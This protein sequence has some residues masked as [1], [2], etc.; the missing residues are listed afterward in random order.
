MS[1]NRFKDHPHERRAVPATRRRAP[2][3]QPGRAVRAIRMIQF[4]YGAFSID[5]RVLLQ[6]YYRLLGVDY[7][8]GKVFP[9]HVE[10]K[11]YDW[12]DETFQFS[13]YLCV[14][15]EESSLVALAAGG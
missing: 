8:M 3:A 6:D 9:G 15:R 10:F 5:T 7:V 12:R 14:R 4:E 1:S 2:Q 11:D 13:N